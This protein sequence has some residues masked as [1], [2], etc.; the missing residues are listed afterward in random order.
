[1]YLVRRWGDGLPVVP[2]TPERVREMLRGTDYRADECLA[3]LAPAFGA[4]TVERIAINAVLA[5]CQPSYL[6]VLIAAVQAVADPRFNLQAVQ[7]TTNAVAVFLLLNGPVAQ[8]LEVNSGY[9]CLGQ[10]WRANATLGRAL[11]MILQN[12]GGALPGEMD[13]ATHGQPGKYTFC[14]A[15]NEA[16]S[17]W[18]P[19]HVERGFPASTSTVTVLGPAGTMNLN[20]HAKDADDLLRVLADSMAFPMSNDYTFG[21]EPAVLLGPEHAEVLARAGLSKAEVKRRLWEG[22]RMPAQRFA[23]KDL[24]RL[25]AGRREE[26]R[27]PVGPD[28]LITLAPSPS[29]FVVVVAGGPSTHSAYLASFGDTRSVTR[30]ITDASGAPIERFGTTSR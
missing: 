10:G 17:P 15:E 23:A 3:I 18:E 13:R 7:A 11:R 6:P 14:C 29:E 27:G 30:A 16:A 25:I 9:N 5:G 22:S 26:L 24:Q 8:Q 4:A 28:T 2:P 21:G 1:L 12:V 19:L 20:S